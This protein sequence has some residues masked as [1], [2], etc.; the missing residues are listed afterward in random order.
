MMV[1]TVGVVA[2]VTAAALTTRMITQGQIDTES[3]ALANRA[4]EEIR[5]GDC[6][7]DG[8]S[9]TPDWAPDP[10]TVQWKAAA[11]GS[12]GA[13]R[14]ISVAVSQPTMR[15]VATRTYSTTLFCGG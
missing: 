1:L 15:G 2:M 3:T 11:V 8:A 10:Y 12:S 13:S 4:F 9:G 7:A 14:Q 6:P 5:G